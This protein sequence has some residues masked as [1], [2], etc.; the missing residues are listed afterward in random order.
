MASVSLNSFNYL[1]SQFIAKTLMSFFWPCYSHLHHLRILEPWYEQ[2]VQKKFPPQNKR[3]NSNY[4]INKGDFSEIMLRLLTRS[5]WANIHPRDLV[6]SVFRCCAQ[7]A[8]FAF[9]HFSRSNRWGS[10]G[11]IT[12]GYKAY[13]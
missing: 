7:R 3:A 1:K 9:D 2:N 4:L 10:T 6:R 11:R 13:R 5:V 8:R 12:R